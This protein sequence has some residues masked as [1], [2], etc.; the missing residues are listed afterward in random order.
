MTQSRWSLKMVFS[1]VLVFSFVVIVS[2]CQKKE[3][4][5]TQVLPLEKVLITDGQPSLALKNLL[6]FLHVEHDNSLASIV[7]ATQKQWLRPAGKEHWQVEDTLQD[8]K[9]Q[10]YPFFRSLNCV[11]KIIPQKSHYIYG[12]LLGAVAFKV[13][14]R[15]TY[16][17]ECWNSGIRFEKFVILG[18]ARPRDV[19]VEPDSSLILQQSGHDLKLKKGWKFNGSFPQTEM[20]IMKLILDQVELPEDMKKIEMIFVEA[21]MQQQEDGTLRRANTIDTINEWLKTQ[22]EPGSCLVFSNQPYIGY[23]HTVVCT[24]LPQTF[25]V[26]TVGREASAQV[27]IVTFLDSLARWLYQEKLFLD[28]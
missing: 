10:L 11:E 19:Q 15:L 4:V 7:E 27:K 9:D 18:S 3:S 1:V 28:R 6:T 25:A 17:I 21:P 22:P 16:L 13:Q 20:G 14:T 24:A 12:L 8:K 23:Q 5:E 26:E 2:S